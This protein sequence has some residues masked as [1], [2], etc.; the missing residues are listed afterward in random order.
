MSG[1]KYLNRNLDSPAKVFYFDFLEKFDNSLKHETDFFI[2]H[3]EVLL[4]HAI[5]K[6]IGQLLS[7]CKH[8]NDI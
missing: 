5:E 6:E 8:A 4:E 2:K 3:S 1:R 7:T